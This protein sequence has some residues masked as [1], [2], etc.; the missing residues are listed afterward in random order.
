MW[1][2]NRVRQPK[3]HCFGKRQD[4]SADTVAKAPDRA[5]VLL[6][7]VQARIH[8]DGTPV[9]E[10]HGEPK[11]HDVRIKL[12]SGNDVRSASLQGHANDVAPCR[13]KHRRF[14]PC[15]TNVRAKYLPRFWAPDRASF[16][17]IDADNANL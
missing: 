8:N 15:Q 9:I 3:N 1:C 14:V 7:T 2:L 5:E 12:P 16:A 10:Y 17:A 6:A 13:H 11:I 4:L